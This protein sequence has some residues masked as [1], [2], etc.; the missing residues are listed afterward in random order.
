MS[1]EETMMLSSFSKNSKNLGVKT[2]INEK[3][4]KVK[5]PL[6]FLFEI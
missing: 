3:I 2:T 6:L 5:T 4:N 1:S